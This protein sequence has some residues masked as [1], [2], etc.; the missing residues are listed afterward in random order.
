ML[1]TL[2]SIWHSSNLGAL[3][4]LK[5]DETNVHKSLCDE[6]APESLHSMRGKP[7]MAKTG[8]KQNKI[9][10]KNVKNK[11]NENIDYIIILI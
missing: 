6:S 7:N 1:Y 10:Q 8:R 2:K 5:F 11:T 9:W 3:D 4:S